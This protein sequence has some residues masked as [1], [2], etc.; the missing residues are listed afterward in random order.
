MIIENHPSDTNTLKRFS[1]FSRIT[2]KNYYQKLF[3]ISCI[4]KIMKVQKNL[5]SSIK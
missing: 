2:V 3:D 4:L 5:V 1:L